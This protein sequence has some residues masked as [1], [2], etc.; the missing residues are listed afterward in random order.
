MRGRHWGKSLSSLGADIGVVSETRLHGSNQH[1]FAVKGL[2]ESGYRAI[3][4]G[5]GDALPRSSVAEYAGLHDEL[6]VGVVLAVR[7]DFL[8]VWSAVHRD[9]AGRGLA[10]NLILQNGLALRV[11]GVYGPTAWMTGGACK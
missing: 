8:G 4:H 6:A 3:S 2:W 1:D 10:G 7:K 11:I 5:S 9:N